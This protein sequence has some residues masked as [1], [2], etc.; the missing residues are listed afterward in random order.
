MGLPVPICALINLQKVAKTMSD[1]NWLFSSRYESI[2]IQEKIHE[3]RVVENIFI[4]SVK[5]NL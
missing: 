2:K 1:K 4:W 3:I 5:S